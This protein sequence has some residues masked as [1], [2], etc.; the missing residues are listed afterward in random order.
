M[1]LAQLD[2]D[3][4]SEL[5]KL[6]NQTVQQHALAYTRQ[7][8]PLTFSAITRY[9]IIRGYKQQGA[10]KQLARFSTFCQNSLILPI[11]DAVLDRAA[12]LWAFALRNGHPHGDADLIIAATALE[13]GRELVTG[14]TPHFTWIPGLTL[15]DWRQP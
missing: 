2:T 3:I 4:L 7:Y 10:T 11:T 13:H 6:R 14:N 12:D 15:A 5:I 8:G 1:P 9:E